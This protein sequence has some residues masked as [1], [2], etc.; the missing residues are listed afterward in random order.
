MLRVVL[1]VVLC[2]VLAVGITGLR[3]GKRAPLQ[4]SETG[5][6]YRCEA[7]S[8]FFQAFHSPD[9]VGDRG[10]APAPYSAYERA[11]LLAEIAFWIGVCL[12][13]VG[14]AVAFGGFLQGNVLVF[15]TG[16]A[17]VA[18]GGWLVDHTYDWHLAAM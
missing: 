5:N 3:F 14:C 12:M 8:G 7:E 13:F 18:A 2:A 17:L 9:N 15:L 11:V 4:Q 16:G 6:S 1:L 10:R